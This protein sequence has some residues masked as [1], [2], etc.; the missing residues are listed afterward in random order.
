MIHKSNLRHRQK[1]FSL[2]ESLLV[3]V[4]L[5]IV[6][7]VATDGL[8]QIQKRSSADQGKLDVNQ[9]SR[10]FMDQITNDLHQAGFP[11]A[12]MY[13]TAYAA[14][15]PNQVAVGMVSLTANTAEF[16]GD[17]DGSG[18]VSHVYLELLGTDGKPIA[19]GNGLCP[20]T[21]QRGVLAKSQVGTGAVPYY[22]EVNNVL[23]T[24]IFSA[25][26]HSGTLVAFPITD[27]TNVRVIRLKVNLRSPVPEVDGTFP[28][29]TMQSAAKIMN[30]KLN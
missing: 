2:L 6:L 17:V 9:M 12:Y 27:F 23:N 28:T 18:T 4:I 29:I 16:E 30:L 7:G 22:T 15:N 5:L 19:A 26:D 21:L 14:A 1:G 8:V 10:Q 25:D 24:D 3:I 20:C 11:S 13:T